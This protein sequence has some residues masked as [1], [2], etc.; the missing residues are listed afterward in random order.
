VV[1]VWM[2]GRGPGGFAHSLRY[3]D[4]RR[5]TIALGIS[6]FG[7][8]AYYVGLTV[9]V[10]Q[11]THSPTWVGIA[12]VGRFVPSLVFGTFGGVLAER[13]ERVRLMVA[14]DATCG[15]IM[16]ALT[17]V[18]ASSGPVSL[19][20]ALA[21][22]NSLL[23][24]TIYQP[25]AAAILPKTVPTSQLVSANAL[26]SSIDGSAVA[27]GSAAAALSLLFAPVWLVFAGN[28]VTYLVSAAVVSRLTVRSLSVDVMHEGGESPLD[29]LK[30]GIR[31]LAASS[32]VATL[33]ACSVGTKLVYGIDS[34]QFVVLSEHRL[35]SGAAGYGYLVAGL[36]VG[37]FIAA[38]V[39]QRIS[40][41]AHIGA[42]ILVAVALYCLPTL[43]FLVIRNPLAGFGLEMVRGAGAL[44]VDV[45]TITAL[46]R[47]LPAARLA[48][49]FGVYVTLS[50][51]AVSLGALVMPPLLSG[52]G[53]DGTL[54]LAGAT[55]PALCA[56]GW[57]WLRRMDRAAAAHLAEIAPRVEVLR[58]AAIFADAPLALLERLATTATELP[59]EAG[60]VIVAQGE[61][62]DAFYV[63]DHGTMAVSVLDPAT[64]SERALPPLRAGHY[65]GEIGLINHTPRT[66]TVAA[67]SR[68]VVLRIDGTEFLEALAAT[69]A[70]PNLLDVVRRRL[71]R[72][73]REPIVAHAR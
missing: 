66:A 60:D 46:Q 25:A 20:I 10:Y 68:G 35:G 57:P 44:V 12:T 42:A 37:G 47:A 7:S 6:A 54:L 38:G 1:V 9:V 29:H 43:A 23:N 41:R 8:W 13:F 62:A 61:H 58:S 19:A 64:G 4:F 34:V 16:L 21:A 56:F 28:A 72:T 2:A 17:A 63:V 65:F 67:S 71:S 26:R 73:A 22:A 14:L 69:T 39:V 70:S 11:Q 33:V 50:L 52:V 24:R 49:V 32:A 5:L 40:A 55:L 59:A 15:C 18:A 48:R 45:L 3:P 51:L 31:A 27:L 53:L 30:V 36:G